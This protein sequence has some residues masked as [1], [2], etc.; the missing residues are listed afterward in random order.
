MN[1]TQ[2]AVVLGGAAAIAWVNWYFLLAPRATGGAVPEPP[3]RGPAG[4]T[5]EEDVG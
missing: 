1:G 5:S 2:L 4:A 3:Q